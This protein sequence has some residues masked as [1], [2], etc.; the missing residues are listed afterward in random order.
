MD[1]DPSNHSLSQH[2]SISPPPDEGGLHVSDCGL[3]DED[4]SGNVDNMGDDG[5]AIN[6]DATGIATTDPKPNMRQ[7]G[8]PKGSKNMAQSVPTES[9]AFIKTDDLNP[10]D[11]LCGKGPRINSYAGNKH[12]LAVVEPRKADYARAETHQEKNGIAREVCRHVRTEVVPNGRFLKRSTQEQA[13]GWGFDSNTDVWVPVDEATMMNRAMQCLREK[14]LMKY[15]V[16]PQVGQD[17]G[18]MAAEAEAEAAAAQHQQHYRHHEGSFTSDEENNIAT[19]FAMS[20]FSND[21]TTTTTATTPPIQVQSP[22]VQTN[23]FPAGLPSPSQSSLGSKAQVPVKEWVNKE[24]VKAMS[25]HGGDVQEADRSYQ[26]NAANLALALMET[27]DL[28]HRNNMAFGDGVIR[29]D[30]ILVSTQEAN[31]NGM[32]VG[33]TNSA[34]F[35]DQSVYSIEI[36]GFGSR[37]P[38]PS[39]NFAD[40]ARADLFNVGAVLYEVFSGVPPFQDQDQDISDSAES[41]IA[42]PS[43]KKK[44]GGM[45]TGAGSKRSCIPLREL[46]LPV[47]IDVLVSQMMKQDEGS[48]YNSA[49]DALEV[50]RYMVHDP[51]SFLFDIDSAGEHGG[52]HV[53]DAHKLAIPKDKLYGRDKDISLLG[54][55]FNRSIRMGGPVECLSVAGYSGTGKTSLVL[56]LRQPLIDLGGYFISGKFDRLRQARPLSA[57]VAALDA[58]CDELISRKDERS[59]RVLQTSIKEAIGDGADVL[60]KLIPNLSKIVAEEEGDSSRGL[61]ADV[62]G[63]EVDFKSHPPTRVSHAEIFPC[64]LVYDASASV[65]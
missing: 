27:V 54:E 46:G 24:M 13:V 60:R 35:Q 14:E 17:Q 50:I 58:Y 11:V 37:S 43:K 8:R 12:F 42:V 30:A 56:Q 23:A 5:G 65:P 7:R 15:K 10:H 19:L 29:S 44:R 45:R 20:S 55:V 28:Y 41:P 53:P 49:A 2:S 36:A 21:S 57:I 61:S 47:A 38:S 1:M 31:N 64:S 51:I 32:V 3:F 40:D 6:A 52:N 33:S 62:A 39:A 18:R 59:F 25:L 9:F 63:E 34:A 22:E 4:N 16:R 48:H 26:L